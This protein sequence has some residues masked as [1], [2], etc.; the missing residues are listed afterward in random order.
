MINYLIVREVIIPDRSPCRAYLL[1]DTAFTEEEAMEKLRKIM[2][3]EWS[4]KK[5]FALLKII[6]DQISTVF[7]QEIPNIKDVLDDE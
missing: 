3:C 6:I 5:V 2:S 1:M 7:P 4:G